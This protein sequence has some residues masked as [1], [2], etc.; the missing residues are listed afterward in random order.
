M[1]LEHI[2]LTISCQG[3][4]NDFYQNLLG[5]EQVKTFTLNKNLSGKIF[6]IFN[7]TPVFHMQKDNLVLEI[8]IYPDKVKQSLNHICLSVKDRETFITKAEAR[9]YECIRIKRDIFDLLISA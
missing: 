9:N 2:A 1:K 5:F 3:D 7:D 8:F 4:I 6:D